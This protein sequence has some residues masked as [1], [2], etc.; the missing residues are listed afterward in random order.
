MCSDARKPKNTSRTKEH[1]L[2]PRAPGKKRTRTREWP[3]PGN[4]RPPAATRAPPR[5]S[6]PVIYPAL[7]WPRPGPSSADNT[8]RSCNR[9]AAALLR[10]ESRKHGRRWRW[11][12]DGRRAEAPHVRGRVSASSSPSSSLPSFR[13]GFRTLIGGKSACSPHLFRDARLDL[14]VWPVRGGGFIFS[15]GS[16]DDRSMIHGCGWSCDLVRAVVS[17]GWLGL[18]LGRA[19]DLRWRVHGPPLVPF[20]CLVC[21]PKFRARRARARFRLKSVG[22]RGKWQ[23]SCFSVRT[24]SVFFENFCFMDVLLAFLF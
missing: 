18:H 5:R 1:A 24:Q 16:H 10:L 13:M 14:L 6:L 21:R 2:D 15:G 17:C 23:R 7:P 3:G 22:Q 9:N 19:T 8:H 20:T 11:R 4:L 12:W